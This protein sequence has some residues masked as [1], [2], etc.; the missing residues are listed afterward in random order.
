MDH[1]IQDADQ[2]IRLDPKSADALVR[3]GAAITDDDNALKRDPKLAPTQFARGGAKR[4][5]DDL[6]GGDADI[7]AA[8]AMVPGI[9]GKMAK[10]GVVP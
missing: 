1:A 7:A 2:A 4:G 9:A 3:R 5:E 8:K 6:S 10:L